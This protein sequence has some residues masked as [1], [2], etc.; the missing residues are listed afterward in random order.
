MVDE[1]INVE[2]HGE[3]LNFRYRDDSLTSSVPVKMTRE[4]LEDH[5]AAGA[6]S[7]TLIQAYA[8]NTDAIHAKVR[9]K[10]KPGVTYTPAQ[11]LELRTADF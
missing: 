10:M 6:E 9:E 5:F 11:P 8:Q 4:A 1:F 2:D 3:W 7:C